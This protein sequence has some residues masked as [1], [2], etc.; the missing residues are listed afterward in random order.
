MQVRWLPAALDNLDSAMEYMPPIIPPLLKKQ[1]N[2]FGILP[3]C[4]LN[5]RVWEDREEYRAHGSR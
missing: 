5:S 1:L 2:A 3:K 4:L